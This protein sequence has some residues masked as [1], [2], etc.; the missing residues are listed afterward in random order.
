MPHLR[1]RNVCTRYSN[2]VCAA[3]TTD[4]YTENVCVEWAEEGGP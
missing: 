1:I 3:W 4:T 2:G